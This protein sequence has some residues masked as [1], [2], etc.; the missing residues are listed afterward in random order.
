MGVIGEQRKE[1]PFA[2]NDKCPGGKVRPPRTSSGPVNPPE[3]RDTISKNRDMPHNLSS[4][5]PHHASTK[6]Y[7]T[8]VQLPKNKGIGGR[9]EQRK[10]PFDIFASQT[11]LQKV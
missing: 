11:V 3:K 7:N 4:T 8:S 2:V 1:D 9:E 10:A 5:L 6:L